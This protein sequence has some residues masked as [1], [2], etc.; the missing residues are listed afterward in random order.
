MVNDG[1]MQ[2]RTTHVETA[3]HEQLD[4][5][6]RIA[7]VILGS[8]N[9][10]ERKKPGVMTSKYFGDDTVGLMNQKRGS[11]LLAVDPNI[12]PNDGPHVPYLGD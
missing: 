11:S 2:K 4:S 7:L 6:P 12:R 8:F 9:E 1:Q 10:I 3:I 5:Q